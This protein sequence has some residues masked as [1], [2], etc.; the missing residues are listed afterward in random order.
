M[1]G[2]IL[3]SGLG[4]LQLA[5]ILNQELLL[6]IADRAG[7]GV[8]PAIV[9]FG[10]ISGRGSTVL[11]IPIA[12]LDGYDEMAAV[13]EGSA[14]S[15]TALTDGS[16]N[17]TI[18]RQSIQRQM[19]DLAG[20]VNGGRVDPSRLA[21][22]M[23]GAAH[24]RLL[25][26]I[27]GLFSSFTSGVGSTGTDF[28]LD[29]FFEG[30]QVLNLAAAPGDGR[31]AILHPIQVADLKASLRAEGNAI[32]YMDAT[33]EMLQAMGPGMN[34]R[35]MG[36]DVF[37]TTRAPSINTNADRQGAML[38][39]GAIGKVFGTRRPMVGDGTGGLRI[40]QGT[41]IYIGFERDEAYTFTKIVGSMYAGVGILQDGLGVKIT[42]DHE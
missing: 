32:S 37:Q 11:K 21:D 42:S 19:S 33:M 17:L 23:V 5:A 16:V 39:R 31:L 25:S 10:D 15:N 40:E 20:I 35:F 29:Q 4:D 7:L 9:D 27:C 3:Y 8:H 12:G 14:S 38:A 36:Y 30:D 24:M 1:S 28:D 26:M 34:G 18:A 41:P 6:K 2:E 22:D 13:A